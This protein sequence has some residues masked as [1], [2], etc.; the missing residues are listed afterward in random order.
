MLPA[1]R[2][3]LLVAVSGVT[4]SMVTSKQCRSKDKIHDR[5]FTSQYLLISINFGNKDHL[6]KWEARKN[7]TLINR[8]EGKREV[9]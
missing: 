1:Y 5:Q 8:K 4:E 2:T 6:N 7:E 9:K 3:A